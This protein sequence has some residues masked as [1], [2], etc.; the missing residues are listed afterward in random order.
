LEKKQPS[1]RNRRLLLIYKP[2]RL[3]LKA[4]KKSR[5]TPTMPKSVIK[6]SGSTWNSFTGCGVQLLLSYIVIPV[7]QRSMGKGDQTEGQDLAVISNLTQHAIWPIS[8]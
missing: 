1:G 3:R 4:S 8:I 6:V 5:I 2:A 7:K